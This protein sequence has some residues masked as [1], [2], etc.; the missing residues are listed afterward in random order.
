MRSGSNGDEEQQEVHPGAEDEPAV[1]VQQGRFTLC[2][3]ERKEF[4]VEGGGLLSLPVA[5]EEGGLF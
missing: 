5:I 1:G 2:F 3:Q 4:L